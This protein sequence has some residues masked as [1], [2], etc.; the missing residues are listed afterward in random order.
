[1]CEGMRRSW[2]KRE[3]EEHLV[4]KPEEKR[5]LERRG[6]RY[7]DNIR[8]ALRGN[9]YEGVGFIRLAYDM[10]SGGKLTFQFCNRREISSR[11]ERLQVYTL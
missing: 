10:N 2:T 3:M 1:M 4:G 9:C 7:K 8:I 6:L 5:L 11:A